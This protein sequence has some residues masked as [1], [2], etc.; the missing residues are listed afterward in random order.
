MA[1]VR[2]LVYVGDVDDVDAAGGAE[3]QV[4]L[5]PGLGV[6]L[7]HLEGELLAALLVGALD[8]LA[9]D[10]Q[11]EDVV[12]DAVVVD[13]RARLDRRRAATLAYNGHEQFIDG[14][15]PVLRG[16]AHPC[17]RPLYHR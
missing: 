12:G 5:P 7:E 10:P 15:E 11:A 8:H 1:V 2:V 6:V 17:V 9:V 3:V 13:Q 16:R 14:L 4:D